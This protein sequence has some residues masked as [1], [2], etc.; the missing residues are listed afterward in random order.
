MAERLISYGGRIIYIAF[1][2]INLSIVPND[3]ISCV[4]SWGEFVEN[5]RICTSKQI[6]IAAAVSK[7]GLVPFIWSRAVRNLNIICV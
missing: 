7:P 3:K 6:M 4:L 1:L 5:N 2:Q